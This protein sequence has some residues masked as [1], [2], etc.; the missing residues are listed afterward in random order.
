MSRYAISHDSEPR[1]AASPAEA[2]AEIRLLRPEDAEVLAQLFLA[3]CA[4][5]ESV[6]Y[7]HPHPLT[8]EFAASLCGRPGHLRDRYFGM[9]RQGSLA[10]YAMLRGWDE[11]YEVPSFG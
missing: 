9:W 5:N 7:F 1:I 2:G 3:L 4:D 8:V 6:R 10:G 11:G